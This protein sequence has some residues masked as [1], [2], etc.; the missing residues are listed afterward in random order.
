MSDKPAAD[1]L[2]YQW[3]LLALV[4]RSAWA[5]GLDKTLAF[6]IIDNYRKEFGNSRASLSYLQRASGADRKAVIASTRRLTEYGPF[7]VNRAGA[8][9]RPTEYKLHFELVHENSSGGAETT[10]TKNRSS[11]GVQTTTGGGAETTTR[12]AS[13]GA[14]TTQSVLPD[15]AYK[16]GIQD[17][18]IEFAAPGAP[19]LAGL[20]AAT[21]GPTKEDG[22]DE[23]WK[24]YS[25]KQKKAEAKAAYA[26]LAPDRELHARMVEAA[27]NWFARWAAQEK[28][29][30]PRFTLARWLEREEYECEPPTAYKA[31]EHK[32]TSAQKPAGPPRGP[33]VVD[34]VDAD[35]DYDGG[36]TV[37]VLTFAERDT[38]TSWK[39]RV[40]LEDKNMDRQQT[41]QREFAQLVNAL[42]LGDVDDSS[43]LCGK[44]V[45]VIERDGELTYAPAVDLK[46]AA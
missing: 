42:G 16:A 43:E 28:P 6:E 22:F 46:E 10:T 15:A 24:A 5:T 26:K 11:S 38:A 34:I 27:G 20:S 31:K 1:S 30:A 14:E 21:A 19:P 41:G 37:L 7:S 32:R 36:S 25:C 44:P 8:G 40:T 39:R 12:S 13:G 17:R 35:V 29:D 3:R 4:L 9:T 18:M 23:L 33:R 2:K 45:T